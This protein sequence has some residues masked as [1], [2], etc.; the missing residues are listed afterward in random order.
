MTHRLDK[1][2]KGDKAY[3]K[4]EEKKKW[5]YRSRVEVERKKGKEIGKEKG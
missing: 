5:R 1:K 3:R 2:T 4:K